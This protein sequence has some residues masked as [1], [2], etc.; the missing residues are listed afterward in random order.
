MSYLNFEEITT[1]I[2]LLATEYGDFC[3]LVTLPH[4]SVET[5]QVH[6]LAL[7][8]T[9]GPDMKTVIYVGGVHAREWIPPDALVYLAADLLEARK[10]GT[11]L[12]YGE[13]RITA[14]EIS[15]IFANMQLLILP[16]ANPDGR[17]YSQEVDPDWRKNRVPNPMPDGGMCHGVDLN[18]NFDVAWDFRR[19]FAPNAV[20]ASDDPCHKYIYVGPEAASEPETRNIVWLLDHYTGARWYLDIHSAVPAVFHNWGL[21]DIQTDTPE[22]NFLNPAHDGQRG[23]AGDTAYREFIEEA[24]AAELLRLSQLMAKEIHKVR[25]DD[26]EVSAAFSLYATSGASDDY[27]YSRHHANQDK[28]KVLGFTMECGHDFQ[29]EFNEAENVMREVSAALVKFA[30]DVSTTAIA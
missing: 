23:I 28:P 30:A 13:A 3:D 29:P 27:A 2:Q 20:S 21:D 22:M 17:V 16:C 14:D 26:Y 24:D 10:G 4:T 18:R 9:R 19:T 12:T 7:G 5:R 6:A 15:Q 11:G 1:G 8:D 25:G